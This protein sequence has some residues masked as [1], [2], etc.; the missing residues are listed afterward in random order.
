VLDSELTSDSIG[1]VDAI[2]AAEN[3]PSRGMASIGV[4]GSQLT[5][6]GERGVMRTNWPRR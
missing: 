4:L 6:L 2:H 5:I 1:P 3:Q